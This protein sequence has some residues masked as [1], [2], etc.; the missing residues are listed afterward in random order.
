[1]LHKVGVI[2]LGVVKTVL[3]LIGALSGFKDLTTTSSK[4]G[5]LVNNS[6]PI[7]ML[8]FHPQSVIQVRLLSITLDNDSIQNWVFQNKSLICNMVSATQGFFQQTLLIVHC[9]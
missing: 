8:M 3:V 7:Y 9:N 6:V 4:A 2:A 5:Q 1:M